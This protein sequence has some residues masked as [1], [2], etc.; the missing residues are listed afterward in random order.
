M[1][2][3][4]SDGQLVEETLGGSAVAFERLVARYERLVFKVAF[5]CIGQ[6]D[7]ALDVVQNVFLKVHR[8]LSGYRIEGDF[9][10]WIA[11]IALNESINWKRTQKRH[12]AKELDER[13]VVPLPPKQESLIRERETWE[14]V[15]RS[16]E[17]LKP[18]YRAAIAL[19]YFE[20]M[21]VREV[22]EILR[23][24]E[25]T[26]KSMLFR[27]LKQM[28]LNIGISEEVAL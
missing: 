25:G 16:M 12:Q 26:V 15:K 8:N 21:S 11:R 13:V 23:C 24:S 18:K 6:R 4:F 7:S 3:E 1:K 27:S 28:R 9:K 20:E 19:R 22:A 5:G 10:N 17:T 2:L 14:M